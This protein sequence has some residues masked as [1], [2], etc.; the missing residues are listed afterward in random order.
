MSFRPFPSAQVEVS[1]AFTDELDYQLAK[2][3]NQNFV[4]KRRAFEIMKKIK[5]NPERY[6]YQPAPG[7][8]S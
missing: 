7:I 2:E 3:G 8:L 6:V 1:N 4:D 5:L